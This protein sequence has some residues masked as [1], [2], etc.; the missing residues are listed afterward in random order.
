[1]A[2]SGR[3]GD[4]VVERGLN[5]YVRVDADELAL[6]RDYW[7]EHEAFWGVVSDRWQSLIEAHGSV[8]IRRPAGRDPLW[9]EMGRLAGEWRE[10]AVAI[11]RERG[12]PARMAM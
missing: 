1:M 3:E 8:A 4:L 11:P 9:R 6:A 12:R 7:T 5:R 10:G 2:V